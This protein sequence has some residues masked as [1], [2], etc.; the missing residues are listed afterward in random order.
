MSI[1]AFSPSIKP[2]VPARKEE[3]SHLR[4][5]VKMRTFDLDALDALDDL[6]E[7]CEVA[8]LRESVGAGRSIV[9]EWSLY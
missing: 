5:V 4:R 6:G 9:G 3:R 7:A 2:A 1:N 8:R